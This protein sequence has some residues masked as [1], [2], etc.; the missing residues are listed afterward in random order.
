MKIRKIFPA[1]LALG[2][3]TACTGENP[4]PIVTGSAPLVIEAAETGFA[5]SRSLKDY[6]APESFTGDWEGLE[7]CYIVHADAAVEMPETEAMPI[8]SVERRSFTQA[9][10]DT[11]LESFIGDSEF[12]EEVGMTKAEIGERLERYRAMERGDIPL[13]LDGERTREDLAEVIERWEKYYAEAPEK[14]EYK[15]AAKE[16][17]DRDYWSEIAGWAEVDGKKIHAVIENSQYRNK[18]VFWQDGYGDRNGT[19]G[20]YASFADEPWEIAISEDEALK[21]GTELMEKL[22]LDV[23][24]DLIEPVVFSVNYSGIGYHMEFVRHVKGLPISYSMYSGT[25]VEENSSGEEIWGYER[26]SVYAA[27]AGIVYFSWEN[28]HTEPVLESEDAKLMAFGDIYDIFGKMIMIKNQYLQAANEANGFDT[29]HNVNVDMVQLSLMRVR[30]KGNFERGLIVPVWDFYGSITA[31]TEDEN[32]KQ[33]VYEGPRYET[34]L[35]LNAIDGTLID[36]EL[37]Y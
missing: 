8:A 29:V 9:D 10:A 20:I 7:G 5:E 1:I 16:F 30:D 21:M 2:M 15:G 36:R 4:E 32:Y 12:Y 26:I 13:E 37:G 27:K 35:S 11:L 31:H 14:G 17:Q 33:Y 24:C 23:V 6:D 19:N 18:A 28:P 25:A 34:L 3:L 22:G